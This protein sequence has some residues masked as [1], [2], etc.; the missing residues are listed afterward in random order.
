MSLRLRL[1]LL[2]GASVAVTVALAALV[3]H[4]AVSTS[5]R[6]EIDDFLA[7]RA[8]TSILQVV[9]PEQLGRRPRANELFQSPDAVVQVLDRRGAVAASLEGAPDLPVD[10]IDRAA[11][12]VGGSAVVRTVEID[13]TEYRMRTEPLPLGAVQI[14]RDLTETN[15]AIR[16]VD[17]RLIGV[18]VVGTAVAALIG[19]AVATRIVGP[20][21]RLADGAEHVAST[22]DL[23]TPVPVERDDEVGTL[24]SSFNAMLSALAL[25]EDQQRRLVQDASHELRTPLT[26]V[27]TNVEV[28]RRSWD[29]LDDAQ[30][31]Q[32]L[33]D[34]EAEVGELS[35]LVAEVV[36]LAAGTGQRDVPADDVDLAAVAERVADRQRRRGATVEV[37]ARGDTAVRGRE[38]DLERAIANIVGNALKFGPTDGPVEIVVDGPS[39]VVHDRG[40]GIPADE[41]EQVFDRFHRAA[42]A[43]GTPGSGLGLAIVAQVAADHGGRAWAAGASGG[44]AAVGF[45]V[46]PVGPRAVPSPDEAAAP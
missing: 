44:G 29:R 25:S 20:I 30:R 22:H 19:W 28:L 9:R 12:G 5:L 41:R 2:V 14:A 26:S 34:V 35:Q 23:R 18:G 11:L 46:D 8:R 32:V 33:A 27:R 15:A 31:E 38:V 10:E 3:A 4:V 36:D 39:V 21:R 43:R 7:E 24:A 6:G 40:P 17:R 16:R 45:R 13:G 37:T 42:G 1:A